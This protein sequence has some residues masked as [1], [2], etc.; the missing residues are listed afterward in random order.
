MCKVVINIR[1]PC[2]NPG[3]PFKLYS[4]HSAEVRCISFNKDDGIVFS[5]GGTDR[6][7]FQWKYFKDN[8]DDGTRKANIGDDDSDLEVESMFGPSVLGDVDNGNVPVKSYLGAMVP[9]S[10]V[11]VEILDAP[12]A[13]D[14]ELDYV[15]GFRSQDVRNNLSYSASGRI[16]YHAASVGISYDRNFHQQTFYKGHVNREII[17]LQ[18][19]YDGRFVATGE[20]C[21]RPRIHIWE[22]TSCAFVSMLPAFHEN[23]VT[24]LSFSPCGQY[25]CSIGQDENHSLC[26]WQ[27]SK[28]TNSVA[29]WEHPKVLAYSKNT[30]KKVLFV[31]FRAGTPTISNPTFAGSTSSAYDIVSGG[32]DHVMFWKI[33][34]PG[35]IGV[36]GIFGNKATLQPIPCGAVVNQRAV[37]GTVTGHLYLW[38]SRSVYRVIPGHTGTVNAIY[39]T[40]PN[41]ALT[42]KIS[43]PRP[44]TDTSLTPYYDSGC[45]TGGLDGHVKLWSK[46]ITPLADFDIS[47]A[48]PSSFNPTIRSVCWD[49]NLNRILVGTRASEIYELSCHGGNSL[50]LQEGHCEDELFA[51]APHPTNTD[52]FVSGGDDKTIR[53]WSISKRDLVG[54]LLLDTAVKSVCW[55]P[56]GAFIAAGLGGSTSSS[57]SQRKD[58]AFAIVDANTMEIVHEGRESKKCLGVLKYSPNGSLLVTGSHDTIVYIHDVLDNYKLRAK[59]DKGTGQITHFDFS[60]D[61]SY[62]RVNTDAYEL[63]FVNTLDGS[64]VP[65]PITMKD[66]SWASE[67]CVFSWPVQGIWPSNDD[68]VHIEACNRA[69]DKDVLVCGDNSANIRVYNYPIITKEVCSLHC[70]IMF[71]NYVGSTAYYKWPRTRGIKS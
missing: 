68:K 8:E 6:C 39:S 5:V 62:L 25:L 71:T 36:R 1:Y 53:V 60:T 14:F 44:N 10:N 28:S 30:I 23:A 27:S 64:W 34:A 70:T 61:S 26:V 58:G 29:E 63:I 69:N 46:E 40:S 35:L 13:I 50:L 32:V 22:A 4:G 52:L 16:V 2:V 42:P 31:V 11:P 57:S 49:L 59:C 41:G 19:S 7:I 51:L 65:S 38:D 56:D 12:P 21:A 47:D 24:Y 17:S 9:P 66:T 48:K 15:H 45:V 43:T 67:S 55:S 54:K 33:D 18:V 20:V 3:A 37:T